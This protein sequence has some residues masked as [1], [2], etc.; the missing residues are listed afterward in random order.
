MRE[1]ALLTSSARR[2]S[3]A[4]IATAVAAVGLTA[5]PAAADSTLP[6]VSAT[7]PAG[8]IVS[9]GDTVSATHPV[10]LSVTTDTGGTITINTADL[11]AGAAR[12]GM[13]VDDHTRY[14]NPR[15]VVPPGGAHLSAASLLID[16]ALVPGSTQYHG[17]GYQVAPQ[18]WLNTVDDSMPAGSGPGL[19]TATKLP[20]GNYTVPL[21]VDQ[22][23]SDNAQGSSLK[24]DVGRPKFFGYGNFAGTGSLLKTGMSARDAI[25]GRMYAF[26]SCSVYCTDSTTITLSV[27]DASWLGATNRV[28]SSSPLLG[29]TYAY[30]G[31]LV[32]SANGNALL[33]RALHKQA[34]AKTVCTTSRLANGWLSTTCVPPKM[35]VMV[36]TVR[37]VIRG[38]VPGD[39]IVKS[40]LLKLT[41][42]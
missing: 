12:N 39:V 35:R 18:I 11:L 34:A 5:M 4:S 38:T 27:A 31:H 26:G 29:M 10:Q 17:P 19:A 7:V 33:T 30:S 37:T 40:G 13:G 16:G 25:A 22:L 41:A 15:F 9:T 24:I 28:L 3:L 23:N 1:P 32:P 20:D 42:N 14:F 2:L 8:G 6:S 36:A 21:N